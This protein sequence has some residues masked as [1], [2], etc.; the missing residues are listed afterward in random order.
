[1]E[2]G[3]IPVIACGWDQGSG[4]G[5]CLGTGQSFLRRFTVAE[6]RRG[7]VATAEHMLNAAEQGGGGAGARWQPW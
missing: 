5:R 3:E 7:G 1:M 4:S 6:A 2:L